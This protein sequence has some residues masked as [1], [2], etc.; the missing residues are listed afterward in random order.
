MEA[1]VQECEND[2]KESEDMM[3]QYKKELKEL[4]RGSKEKLSKMKEINKYQQ[5]KGEAK[6]ALDAA[7][8]ELRS[9][10]C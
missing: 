2:L 10:C 1:R 5:K 7:K 6:T 9:L 3:L 8:E 4:P